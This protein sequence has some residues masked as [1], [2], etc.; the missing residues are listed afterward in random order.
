MTDVADRHWGTSQVRAPTAK[1]AAH[2]DQ[3]GEPPPPAPQPSNRARATRGVPTLLRTT[4]DGSSGLVGMA[5]PVTAAWESAP[6]GR[7]IPAA[8][9]VAPPAPLAAVADPAPAVP[10]GALASTTK[11]ARPVAGVLGLAPATPPVLPELPPVPVLRPSTV[12][13][14]SPS[15]GIAPGATVL[16][17]PVAEAGAAHTETLAD[18][19]LAR[20]ARGVQDCARAL[21]S[22]ADRI[23]GLERRLDGVDHPAGRH[24]AAAAGP[25]EAIE[26]RLRALEGLADDRLQGLDQRLRPLEILPAAVSRLQQDLVLLADLGRV[27]RPDGGGGSDLDAVYEELDSVAELVSAHHGAAAQS[28]ERVRTL[29]RAVLE[30]RRHL[31]RNQ[32]EHA[33]VATAELTTAK[34]RLDRLEARVHAAELSSPPAR[35]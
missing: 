18:P 12:A 1:S 25:S 17:W 15:P 32:A 11:P 16:Q 10:A 3:P 34:D 5:A 28:L 21:A 19:S 35:S 4:L 20:L 29:E 6:A 33:R 8:P 31:E 23:D 2:P 30:M 22:L 7:L 26:V 24:G 14:A 9:A 13:A 27:G